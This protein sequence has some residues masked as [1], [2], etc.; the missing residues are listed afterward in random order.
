MIGKKVLHYKITEK[1][2]Q[3][4]MG[5]VYMA[6]DTKLK[7]TVALKFLPPQA[8]ADETDKAR[9]VHEAQAAAALHHP[10]ICTV[11]EINEADE[12]V[13]ISMAYLP[14]DSLKEKIEAGPIK[15]VDVLK[16]ATQIARGLGAAHVKQIVHR[17]I[18]PT[19]I[20]F[21]ES[22]A[23]TVLD[24]G[25]AKSK[26]QTHVTKMGTT[27]GTIAYM[28]PEQSRGVD[29]D[30]RTDIWSLGVMMYE[31]VTGQRPFI[32]DY[33]EAVIYSILNE[34]AKPI[35]ELGKDVNPDLIYIINKAMAKSPDD[36]YQ[37]AE[38]MLADMNPLL[39]ALRTGSSSSFST[40]SRIGI[41]GTHAAASGL[42]R[43]KVLFPVAAVVLVVAVALILMVTGD[44]G[45]VTETVAVVDE[46]GQTIERVVPK[47]EFR[48]NFALYPFENKTGDA[49]N[50]WVEAASV[51]LLEIDLLQDQ[52]LNVRSANDQFA[53]RKLQ[54]AGFRKWSEAPWNLKRRIAKESQYDF[55]VTGTFTIE[56]G[57]YVFSR[58]LHNT[59]T[60]R[61]VT[62]KE[63]RGK[64]VF[65]IID[66][67][68]VDL[69]TDLEVPEAYLENLKDL[70][71]AE[72]MTTSD[73]ALK[74][75]GI[76]VQALTV[77][78]DWT[79]A[80]ESLLKAVEVDSTFAFAHWQLL[81]MGLNTNQSQ[82]MA[83]SSQKVIQYVYKLPE[84]VQ[85]IVKSVYYQLKK[86]TNKQVAVLKMM[87]ELY[88]ED[89]IGLSM[90][91]QQYAT[92]KR[93]DEAIA[94]YERIL[95][96]DPSRS[97]TLR[98]I[99]QLYRNEGEFDRALEYFNQYAS[100]YPNQVNSFTPIAVIYRD[101]GEYD[102][103]TE[104]YDKALLI[105]PGN[106]SVIC[107]LGQIDARLGN[108]EQALTKYNEA[109]GLAKAPRDRLEIYSSLATFYRD[110]GE[111]QKSFE[112][113]ILEWAEEGVVTSPVQSLLSELMEA[114][115]YVK[116]GER[117]KAF[118]IV[119]SVGAKIQAPYDE[120]VPLGYVYLYLEVEEPDSAEV[121]AE[122]L[123]AFIEGYKLET[124]R[125]RV[126]DIQGRV[127]ELR[128]RY[129]EA[130]G[131]FEKRLEHSP[132]AVD[133]YWRIGRCYHKL[134]DLDSAELNLQKNLKIFPVDPECLFDL[135]L[136]QADKGE[137][138]N[139]R[140]TL[141][142]VLEIWANADPEFEP[143]RKA[144]EKLVEW[145]SWES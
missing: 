115:Y 134:G 4:G 35:E 6:E 45:G 117:D 75:F 1:L 86:D 118:E 98:T 101:M 104:Y 31:M 69:K 92:E 42:F 83:T 102:K 43:P 40:R 13:F 24:F 8:L 89:T 109:L 71:V 39:D 51:V 12:Q 73:E 64:D 127:A 72:M 27:M 106:V 2:G 108:Y 70:P 18:K 26:H 17:D 41:T 20:M 116:A 55:I 113:M 145:Q 59:A 32:G 28:S 132:R 36:R 78:Q 133:A 141:D 136:V 66:D 65:A 137:R 110:R 84:R 119:E 3:G 29:V 111:M 128:G 114:H 54:R 14:G 25:L 126:F 10:N 79:T 130:I 135:A 138:E 90:L 37:S 47:S 87:N 82:I 81:I 58:S 60:G 16:I 120:A 19:N 38:E 62:Q 97:E 23:A 144:R 22:G 63:Y 125:G 50:D 91:A 99:G 93:T 103:S 140:A 129:E 67:I 76:G 57:D 142:K 46:E 77:D 49:A 30:H 124:L 105:E 94:V 52:I 7:R 122:R 48:K 121:A 74:D 9:F 85:F 100:L 107:Q 143:A 33:D 139:A 68:S 34:P 44:K 96:I 131:H 123:M 80:V 11:F 61:M 21:S 53:M 95:E 88:P 15:D 5:A 112:Y 56:N